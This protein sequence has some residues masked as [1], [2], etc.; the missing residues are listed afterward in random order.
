MA[1]RS[2]S[3]VWIAAAAALVAGASALP[4]AAH[5]AGDA[6]FVDPASIQWGDAPPGLPKGAKIALLHGDPGKPGSA[7]VR[8]KLP[9]N[10]RIAPH[11]HSKDEDLTVLSGALYLGLSE[12][13]EPKQA[14][15]LQVGGF[16]HLPAKT[17]HYVFTKSPTIVEVHLEGPFDIVYVN[18]AD[19]PS[20]AAPKP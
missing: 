5:G 1:A 16:H 17:V 18:P 10:Y 4:I 11:T 19:D 15:A 7:T 12:K 3:P 8:L 20:K 13:V 9:A 14:H 6:S 2:G